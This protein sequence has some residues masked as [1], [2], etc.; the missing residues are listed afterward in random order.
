MHSQG[1][2]LA[3]SGHYN[4]ARSRRHVE[5][6][7]EFLGLVETALKQGSL[8]GF[9]ENAFAAAELL[10]KAELISLPD[11]ALLRGTHKTIIGAYNLWAKLGN[12]EP[13]FAHLLNELN[14]LRPAGRY[15]QGELELDG[16]AA[17][18]HLQTLRDML[19]HVENVLPKRGLKEDG[20]RRSVTLVAHKD[21]KAGEPVVA[22]R[23]LGVLLR[24]PGT[25]YEGD[26]G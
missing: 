9:A 6:A 22:P 1:W 16:A 11:E 12:A 17:E 3:F 20:G 24:K 25:P 14:R 2:S 15:V 10:A 26:S 8:H 18:T 13:R 5:T 4:F 21:M 7:H 23:P 19:A